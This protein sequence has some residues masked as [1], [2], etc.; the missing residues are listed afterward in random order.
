MP[1]ITREQ[2][3]M[4][5]G[6]LLGD[7]NDGLK[8]A[9]ED[10]VC[11]LSSSLRKV[12]DRLADEVDDLQQDNEAM[13]IEIEELKARIHELEAYKTAAESQAKKAE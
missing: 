3:E 4:E 8:S 2:S 13:L 9:A 1:N 6:R 11:G 7:A 5:I 10:A 12:F